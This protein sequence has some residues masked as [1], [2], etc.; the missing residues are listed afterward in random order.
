MAVRIYVLF[1]LCFFLMFGCYNFN[2]PV[3]PEADNYQGFRSDLLPD[4]SY[5]REVAIT[6]SG[7]ALNDYQVL[8][9]LNTA[10]MGS[11]YQNVN[12]DG[13]DLRF[14]D[15]SDSP[16]PYWIESWNNTGDSLVWVRVPSVPA[17]S[18]GIYMYYG[19][20]AA[21]TQS[22]GNATFLFFDDFE[23]H[24]AGDIADG[25]QPAGI[26]QVVDDGGLKVLDDGTGSG[27]AVVA[28]HIN[29][30]SLS[31]RQRFRS[32]DGVID[33]AGLVLWYASDTHMIYAGPQTVST[34]SLWEINGNPNFTLIGGY[35]PIS[36]SL[37]TAWH[38]QEVSIATTSVTVQ[39]DD[40]VIGTGST[41]FGSS[42]GYTGFWSQYNGN[43]A[44]RD[45]HLARRYAEPEPSAVVGAEQPL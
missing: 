34:G 14:T 3:D 35:F 22:D 6:N 11:P 33:Y 23:D 30:Q 21:T 1:V 2:N 20:A 13:S 16:L 31:V 40:T 38:I 24:A 39:L 8:A 25:W 5:R 26:Y 28:G 10:T 29:S 19:D 15:P 45:W 7:V 12:A 18:S 44:Y 32:V 43:R 41:S 17:G 37:D 27:E 36:P 9:R 42:G 4:A